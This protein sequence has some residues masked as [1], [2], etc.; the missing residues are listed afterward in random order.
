MFYKR[1]FNK[2]L[3]VSASLA[4]FISSL[5]TYSNYNNTYNKISALDDEVVETIDFEGMIGHDSF[6]NEEAKVQD[7]WTIVRGGV[8]KSSYAINGKRALRLTLTSDTN[9]YPYAIYTFIDSININKIS[10]LYHSNCVNA[11]TY[12]I[13]TSTNGVDYTEAFT[14][15]PSSST[16]GTSFEV[17]L[18]NNTNVKYLKIALDQNTN[19]PSSGNKSTVFDDIKLYGVKNYTRFTSLATLSSLKFDF[20]IST[21]D[22]VNNYEVNNMAIRFGLTNMPLDLYNSLSLEGYTFGVAV[23]FDNTNFKYKECNNIDTSSNND[24]ASYYLLINN[25]PITNW[26]D[27]IYAKA[28]ITKDN[29]NYYYANKKSHSIVSLANYYVDNLSNNPSVSPYIDILSYIGGINN[30]N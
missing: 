27:V 10:F 18:E 15:I 11:A 21:V 24:Y 6:S 22:E 16:K 26:H 14:F 8:G 9:N 17:I 7:N 1:V 5:V 28:Y 20:I 23:S 30:G 13:S 19:K 29:V 2:M 25:V 12:N 3:L 4:L